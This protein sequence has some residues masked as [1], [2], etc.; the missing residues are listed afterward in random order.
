MYV[1]ELAAELDTLDP[2]AEV[3]VRVQHITDDED[4]AYDDVNEVIG[5]FATIDIRSGVSVEYGKVVIIGD[6]PDPE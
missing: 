1:R 5:T 3:V 6:L 2:Y 4:V